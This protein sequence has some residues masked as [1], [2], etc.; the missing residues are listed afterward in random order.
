[1]FDL[2]PFRRGGNDIFS[3]FDE[4]EKNFMK[5]FGDQLPAFKTDIVDKGDKF[6]LE[7]EMPGFDKEDINIHLEDIC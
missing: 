7:A 2:A 6:V 5:N 4:M 1:M 3:F